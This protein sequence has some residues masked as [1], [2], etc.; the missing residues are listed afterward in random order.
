M[1]SLFA[2]RGSLFAQNSKTNLFSLL[3]RHTPLLG[4]CR[5]INPLPQPTPKHQ[6]SKK[7]KNLPPVRKNNC[8]TSAALMQ[9]RECGHECDGINFAAQMC[10]YKWMLQHECGSV[11]GPM[12]PQAA[13]ILHEVV[14]MSL[15]IN[16]TLVIAL[17]EALVHAL[18]HSVACHSPHWGACSC[19]CRG[20]ARFT[21]CTIGLKKM[22]RM[23]IWHTWCKLTRNQLEL[24]EIFKNQQIQYKGPAWC[25]LQN[26]EVN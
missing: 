17:D 8:C 16:E 23:K 10:W 24:K 19:S 3:Y 18:V 9:L 13:C 4:I 20:P 12:G 22:K 15:M 14:K 25:Y 6:F 1:G 7:T 5:Y 11:R 26:T 2:Q 21:F